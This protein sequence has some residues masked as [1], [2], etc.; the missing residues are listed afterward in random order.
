MN[1]V[2]GIK[3]Q[4]FSDGHMSE[5][6]SLIGAGEGPT[7]TA[8][9]AAVPA[10]LSA[11]AN[12]ASSDSGAEKLAS[13]VNQFDSGGL[14]NLGRMLTRQPDSAVEHGGGLLGSLFGNATTSGIVNALSKFTG[15][16]PGP[17][18]KLVSFLMPMILGAIAARFTGKAV[19]G[20]AVKS[21]LGEEKSNIAHALP[22]GL[23]LSDVPGL[24]TARSAARAAVNTAGSTARAAVDTT[25]EAGTT[26]LKWLLPGILGL[27]V[28]CLLAWFAYKGLSAVPKVS[29]IPSLPITTPA[30]PDISKLNTDLKGTF[31][32]LTDSLGEIKSA[33]D[34]EK[35]LPKLKE[36][37][38]KLDGLTA[39]VDKL[40]EAER[41]KVI[42]PFKPSLAKLQDQFAKLLWIPGVGEKIKPVFD[43][44]NNLAALGGLPVPKLGS[45]SG[46]LAGTVTS[47][48]ESLSGIKDAASAEK[49]LPKLTELGDK[50]KDLKVEVDKLP[51]A[52][53]TTIS[54]LLKDALVKLKEV[55]DKVLAIPGVSEKIKPAVDSV[56]DTFTKLAA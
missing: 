14:A 49:A 19:T 28:L 36:F 53:Q 32:S 43:K 34:A 11:L 6:G 52:E 35:A 21:L 44:V 38:T 51:E 29:A 23:S 5:L 39:L 2:D 26:F 18:Q 30:L 25:Q 16:P 37:G 45:V 54:K 7:K 47:L 50:A 55:V 31:T 17:I 20:P 42:E 48:T 3:N 41:A 33:A 22:S 15:I 1:L 27:A 12:T 10:V 56:I 8:V 40:P 13:A 4:L 24:A 46:D 9:G